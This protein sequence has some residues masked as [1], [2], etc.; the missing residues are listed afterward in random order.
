MKSTEIRIGNL[1]MCRGAL[2]RVT[3]IHENDRIGY[4][5][6]SGIG[7]SNISIK[8]FVQPI[9]LTEEWL[10]RFGFIRFEGWDGMNFWIFEKDKSTY[11]RF[12]ILET[13]QGYELPSGKICEHVHILQN[14]YYFHE[15]TGEELTIKD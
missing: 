12:E 9:P 3:A 13:E 1:V 6:S 4:K 15:L 11:E 14:A 5:K 10:E 8:R 7:E 2:S